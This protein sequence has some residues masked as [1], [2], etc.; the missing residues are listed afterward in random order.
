MHVWVYFNLLTFEKGGT[1]HIGGIMEDISF[2]TLDPEPSFAIDFN[3]PDSF[4]FVTNHI[5]G[6]KEEISFSTL[7]PEPIFVI[8]FNRPDSFK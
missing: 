1:N 5:G 6:I 4:K 3:R 7:D 8:D 2:S